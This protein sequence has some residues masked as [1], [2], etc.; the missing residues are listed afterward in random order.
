MHMASSWREAR[1][2]ART[3][4]LSQ[5]FHDCDTDT[6][7]ACREGEPQGTFKGGVF[8]EHRCICM[9]ARLSAEEPEEKEQ[10]FRKENPDW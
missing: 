9:P 5:V 1:D 2:A 3:S 10:K 8:S 4:G 6:Y 7:G